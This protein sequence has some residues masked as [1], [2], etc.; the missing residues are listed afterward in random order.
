MAAVLYDLELG[1]IPNALTVTGLA[2]GLVW[3][4]S[5][6]GILGLLLFFGGALL[7]VLLLGVLYYFRMIGAGD[8]KLFM[9]LGAFLGPGGVLSCILRSAVIGAAFA[10]FLLLSRRILTERLQYFLCYI[11][12]SQDGPWKPYLSDNGGKARFCFSLSV[13]MSVIFCIITGG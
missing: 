4:L 5:C 13:L 7:P 8:I 9:A 10:L 12:D 1:L 2:M 6:H 11:A 3:Q